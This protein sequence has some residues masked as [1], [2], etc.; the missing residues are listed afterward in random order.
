MFLT[1]PPRL[2]AA[3]SLASRMRVAAAPA[4]SVAS[5]SGAALAARGAPARP[6]MALALGSG[7][8]AYSSLSRRPPPP[9]RS[10]QSP[11][12]SPS[13]SSSLRS[14]SRPLLLQPRLAAAAAWA[15]A[16]LGGAAPSRASTTIPRAVLRLVR[17]GGA[18]RT[19]SA[20]KKRFRVNGGGLLIRKQSGKREWRLAARRPRALAARRGAAWRAR[21]CARALTPPPRSSYSLALPV[22]PSPLASPLLASQGT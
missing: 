21:F 2:A 19:K 1:L 16:P 9:S 15:S 11:S 8:T 10:P 20:V 17:G 7:A 22:R 12:P 13:P 4:T 3:F 6:V 14:R 5:A 18:N